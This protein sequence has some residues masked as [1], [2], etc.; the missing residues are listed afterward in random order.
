MISSP[1]VSPTQAPLMFSFNRFSGLSRSFKPKYNVALSTIETPNVVTSNKAYI[2]AASNA[3]VTVTVGEIS[4]D[5]GSTWVTSGTRGTF[6]YLLMRGE[7]SVDYST[8]VINSVTIGGVEYTFTIWTL[9]DPSTLNAQFPYT[10]PFV[11]G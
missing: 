6:K 11:L 4:L 1:L 9:V 8:A 2:V 10:F 3:V 5:G 7:A